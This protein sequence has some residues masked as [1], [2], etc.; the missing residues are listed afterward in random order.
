MDALPVAENIGLPYA[1]QVR[2]LDPDGRE[3]PVMHACGHDV[4]VTCLLGAAAVLAADTSWAG[5][6]VAVFQPAEEVAQGATAMV[7]D[8][9]YDTVPRPDVVLGQHVAPIPAGYLGLQQ[10]QR[11]HAGPDQHGDA[12]DERHHSLDDRPAPVRLTA[13]PERR[14]HVPWLPA[15]CTARRCLYS[16]PDDRGYVVQD[17]RRPA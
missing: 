12:G 8:G 16:Q 11:G 10:E 9:L 17:R 14:I 3:V 15:R 7:E 6:V 2:G 5:T 13:C 1:S 4:H